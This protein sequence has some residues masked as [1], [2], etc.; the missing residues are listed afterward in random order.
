MKAINLM[1]DD[2]EVITDPEI[3]DDLEYFA[4]DLTDG[5]GRAVR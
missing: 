5:V 2:R 1:L 4:R 3:R